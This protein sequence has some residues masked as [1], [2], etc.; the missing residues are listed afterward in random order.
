MGIQWGDSQLGV[1]IPKYVTPNLKEKKKKQTRAP[2][3][4][5]LTA[6][7]DAACFLRSRAASVAS[8]DNCAP[9]GNTF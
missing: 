3:P 1:L 7:Q 5:L 2:E 4:F 6:L 9:H 8:D